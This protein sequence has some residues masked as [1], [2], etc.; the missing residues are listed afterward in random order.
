MD[1]MGELEPERQKERE[2]IDRLPRFQRS[3]KRPRK[4]LGHGTK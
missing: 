1:L 3:F 4:F 2:V